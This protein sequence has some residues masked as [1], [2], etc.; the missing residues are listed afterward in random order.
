[1]EVGDEDGLT[2]VASV[3]VGPVLIKVEERYAELL[4]LDVDTGGLANEAEP[5]G[6]AYVSTTKKTA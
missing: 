3:T 6:F 2:H 4:E 1:M 5:Q